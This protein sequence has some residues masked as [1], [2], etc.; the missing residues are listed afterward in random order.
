MCPPWDPNTPKWAFRLAILVVIFWFSL[1]G[2][3]VRTAPELMGST[4][5]TL[6]P[7][8][9][10]RSGVADSLNQKYFGDR[11][12]EG[13]VL[14]VVI[15]AAKG[16]FI[17]EGTTEEQV[18]AFENWFSSKVHRS[19]FNDYYSLNVGGYYLP[20]TDGGP[21]DWMLSTDNT[22]T[23]ITCS[24]NGTFGHH[25]ASEDDVYSFISFIEAEIAN[26]TIL[27]DDIRVTLAGENVL[28]LEMEGRAVA[29]LRKMEIIVL[30]FAF[31][32][33]AFFLRRLQLLIVPLLCMGL[34]LGASFTFALPIAQRWGDVS[35]ETPEVM[36]SAAVALSVDYSLF[37]LRRYVD[38]TESGTS[39]WESIQLMMRHSGH[40]ISVSGL[41]ISLA[42]LS[43]VLLPLATIRAAGVCTGISAIATV[44]C[45]LTATPAMLV[46]FGRWLTSPIPIPFAKTFRKV[47]N[48]FRTGPTGEGYKRVATDPKLGDLWP[49]EY[50]DSVP[51]SSKLSQ[52]RLYDPDGL[53]VVDIQCN[54]QH[55]PQTATST[56]SDLELIQDT[57]WYKLGTFIHKHATLVIIIIL[58]LGTP[59]LYKLKDF[60]VSENR[61]LTRP[62]DAKS[63]SAIMRMQKAG[64]APGRLQNYVILML[65]ADMWSETGFQAMRD[66][67]EDIVSVTNSSEFIKHNPIVV[68]NRILEGPAHVWGTELN[69]SEA[70]Q[71]AVS[72]GYYRDILEKHSSGHNVT[73]ISVFTPFVPYGARSSSW[74][75][76][77]RDKIDDSNRKTLPDGIQAY[78]LGADD[79]DSAA[80]VMGTMPQLI[81]I[82]LAT[83]MVVVS[84]SFQS[85]V[86]PI[87]LALA[88]AY[89]ITI[90]LS[91]AVIVYQ[92]PAFWWLFPYLEDFEC[93]GLSYSVPA[94]VIPVCISL[95]I[96]YDIFLITRIFEYRTSGMSDND[97]IIFGLARTGSTITGAGIIMCIAFGGLLASSETMLNQFGLVLTV[98][99]FLDTFVIRTVLVPALMFKA[100]RWNWWPRTMPPPTTCYTVL[101][102]TADGALEWD[103]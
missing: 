30:P 18:S 4:G 66:L 50:G 59:L 15:E 31:A 83:V 42:F 51:V 36:I 28:T 70:Q 91:V 19:V 71:R 46:L 54:I 95:G 79:I 33:L 10:S 12:Y 97:S 63:A 11:K 9:N 77:I 67:G 92:T 82:I 80:V 8:K 45:N 47:T 17:N 26:C 69:F 38:E 93:E 5:G 37:L 1:G 27:D 78:L 43:G 61:F 52:P 7:P 22:T 49:V 89:T 41:L 34:S 96:D 65:G 60:K 25:N 48:R 3:C 98:S 90:T 44:V 6:R 99:V 100:S 32:V 81:A 102:K 76:Q 20:S 84:I 103:P 101:P 73:T 57:A 2:L 58:S 64:I 72:D 56:S 86:L 55:S 87:R 68:D 40:T 29:S 23:V 62:R 94:I 53:E 35:S 13:S 88:L 75:L 24:V 85:L 39:Q 16:K 14:D 21:V 74:V